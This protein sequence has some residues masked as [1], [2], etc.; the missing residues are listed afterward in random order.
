M[1]DGENEGA[2]YR[3]SLIHML[4]SQRPARDLPVACAAH[5]RGARSSGAAIV[6]VL[7]HNFH[8]AC[9]GPGRG[10]GQGQ[11]QGEALV[12]GMRL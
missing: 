11:Q 1:E 6:V 10:S 7:Q 5:R 9:S 3:V 4:V 12:P 2:C 8:T